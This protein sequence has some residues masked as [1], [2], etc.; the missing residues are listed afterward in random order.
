VADCSLALP[1]QMVLQQPPP[2]LSLLALSARHAEGRQ[3]AAELRL[4]ACR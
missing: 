4:A 1:E 2:A 3:A